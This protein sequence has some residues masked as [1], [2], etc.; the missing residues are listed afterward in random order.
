MEPARSVA[1]Q[2]ATVAIVW[3]LFGVVLVLLNVFSAVRLSRSQFGSHLALYVPHVIFFLLGVVSLWGGL[4]HLRRNRLGPPMLKI[5]SVLVLLY[6]ASF[7]PFHRPA[8]TGV[9]STIVVVM[10]SVLAV[11][12][13]VVMRRRSATAP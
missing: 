2:E 7:F 1:R 6:S 8:D 11:W 4:G 12:T 5:S 13:F 9:V 10:V 3:S